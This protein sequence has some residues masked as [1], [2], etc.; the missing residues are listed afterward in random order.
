MM[1]YYAILCFVAAVLCIGVGGAVVILGRCS[2]AHRAFAGGMLVLAAEAVFQ[3]L[4]VHSVISADV[5]WWSCLRAVATAL[6]PGVWLIFGVTYAQKDPRALLTRWKYGIV[7]AFAVP[8]AI[9]VPFSS[10]LYTTAHSVAPPSQW[11][12]PLGRAGYTLH[13]ALVLG[14]TAVLVNLERTLRASAGMTRWR[15]KFVLLGLGSLFA[16]RIF[17]ASQTLLFS[18]W[19]TELA[20]V[21]IFAVYAAMALIAISL[22]RG[23]FSKLDLYL[24]QQTL[25]KSFT[26]LVT[27]LYFLTVGVMAKLIDF[28]GGFPS[29]V[30]NAFLLFLAFL[31]LGILL[32]SDR[33]NFRIKQAIS[34]HLRRPRHDYRQV[35][36]EFAHQTTNIVDLRDLAEIVSKT[37]SRHL[38]MLKVSFWVLNEGMDRLNLAGSTLSAG[39]GGRHLVTQPAWNEGFVELHAG[40]VLVDFQEA[41]LPPWAQEF[42]TA[43]EPDLTEAG[44][45]YAVPLVSNDHFLGIIGLD[46]RVTHAPLEFD[47]VDLLKA[48]CDHVAAELLNMTLS[49]QLSRAREFE[50]FQRVSA[51]FAHDLKN[52]ASRLSLTMQNFESNFDDPEF[53]RDALGVIAGSVKKVNDLCQRLSGFKESLEPERVETDLNALVQATVAGMNGCIRGSVLLDLQ[54]VGRVAVDPEEIRKILVNLLLNASDAIGEEGRIRVS[55]SLTDRW[56]VIAVTDNGC[57]MSREFME[58]SLFQPFKTTKSKGLGIGLHQSK[59]IVEAHGGRMEVESTEKVGTTF[60][61]LLPLSG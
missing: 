30:T 58:R 51:F 57:G 59:A 46:E 17:T 22:V 6:L 44:V 53:R 7:A 31:G 60:R 26:I 20:M 18:M 32:L 14:L 49:I 41:V 27:G 61:V 21:N 54:P 13:I 9:V 15:L 50:M 42:K 38:D 52:V 47:D 2:T 1:D 16:A 36:M 40:P 29:L 11:L 28:F 37:V 33:L 23:S 56:A 8:L 43:S 10:S 19:D 45:R 24:S 48:L 4:V 3:G 5:L 35:W 39:E 12:L 55:T 25:H 34:R